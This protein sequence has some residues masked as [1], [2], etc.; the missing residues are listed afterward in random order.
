MCC[1]EPPKR[2]ARVRKGTV[3]S[4]PRTLQREEEAFDKAQLSVATSFSALRPGVLHP[5]SILPSP[6][7][8][9]T[10]SQSTSSPRFFPPPPM[11]DS[12]TP[13]MLNT[14]KKFGGKQLKQACVGSVIPVSKSA[15]SEES[16]GSHRASPDFIGEQVMRLQPMNQH[17]MP[18]ISHYP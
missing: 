3:S 12:S 18:Y 9:S 6:S 15:S 17:I 11:Q 1:I 4:P 10:S 5:P 8:S 2:P 14:G 16:G 7:V 13:K